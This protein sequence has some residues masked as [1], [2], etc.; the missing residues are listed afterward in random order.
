MPAK[1]LLARTALALLCVSMRPAA[2]AQNGCAAQLQPLKPV[3]PVGCQDTRPVCACAGLNCAWIWACAEPNTPTWNPAQAILDGRLNAQRLRNLRLQ[4]QALEESI[5]RSRV[6]ASLTPIA[7]DM[8]AST[9]SPDASLTYDLYNGRFWNRLSGQ[10]K[11]LYVRGARDARTQ[12]PKGNAPT[13]IAVGWTFTEIRG[14][15]DLLY[16]VPENAAIPIVDAMRI[17]S[18]R[19]GGVSPTEILSEVTTMRFAA[20]AAPEQK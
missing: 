14:E 12:L 8:L 9:P 1:R 18:L 6:A 7:P 3:T 10:E 2:F 5:Q 20:A 11:L 19:L 13:F 15:L 17:A 16:S 4:N